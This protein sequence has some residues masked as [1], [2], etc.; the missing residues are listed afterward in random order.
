MPLGASPQARARR[1]PPP[2]PP[3]WAAPL[4]HTAPPH[5]CSAAL[6]PPTAC[7]WAAGSGG[8]S[9]STHWLQ[10]GLQPGLQ[11]GLPAA[12]FWPAPRAMPPHPPVLRLHPPHRRRQLRSLLQILCRMPPAPLPLLPRG[13]T[14]VAVLG[15][16][17]GA[18]LL[19]GT[20]QRAAGEEMEGRRRRRRRAGGRAARRR[21]HVGAGARLIQRCGTPPTGPRRPRACAP[22]L[23]Q[24]PRA[25]KQRRRLLPVQAPPQQPRGGQLGGLLPQPLRLRQ[26]VTHGAC[27]PRGVDRSSEPARGRR[28]ASAAMAVAGGRVVAALVLLLVRVVCCSELPHLAIP[29]VG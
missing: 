4:Q 8:L 1:A 24:L 26:A 29:G 15:A 21:L 7:T 28:G 9:R 3:Q 18:R 2:L 23:E 6:P 14:L 17:V 5:G 12:M 25:L 13:R 22:N 10:E 27:R 19:Q 11:E 20:R 16:G